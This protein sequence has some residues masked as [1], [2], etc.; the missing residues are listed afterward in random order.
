MVVH[1]KLVAVFVAG[2]AQA[3]HGLVFEERLRVTE[4]AELQLIGPD[5]LREV[6]RGEARRA[7]F[8]HQDQHPA[9]GQF[10]GHP[11]AA[12]ARTDDQCVKHSKLG[13]ANLHESRIVGHSKA[14]WD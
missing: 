6:A 13:L 7:G 4:A 8:E 5:V 3:L 9:L 11:T 14:M 12:R 2:V 1:E 10:L